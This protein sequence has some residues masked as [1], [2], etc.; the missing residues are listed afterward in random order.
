MAIEMYFSVN[1]NL[2]QHINHLYIENTKT[3][4]GTGETNIGTDEI[5]TYTS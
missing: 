5:R 1:M 4:G 2:I 3:S